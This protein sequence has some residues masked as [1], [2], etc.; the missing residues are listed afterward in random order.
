MVEDV[1]IKYGRFQVQPWR[2]KNLKQEALSDEEIE[3][4]IKYRRYYLQKM[5]EWFCKKVVSPPTEE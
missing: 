2:M 3:N 1:I 4:I 5:H